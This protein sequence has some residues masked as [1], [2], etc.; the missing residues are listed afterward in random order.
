M[1]KKRS[2]DFAKHLNIIEKDIKG[3]MDKYNE[4]NNII[5]T[6]NLINQNNE[7]DK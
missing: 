6:N 2:N 5:D 4:L 3:F 7:S 1:D